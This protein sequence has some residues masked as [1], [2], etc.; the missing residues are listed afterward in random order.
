VRHIYYLPFY[1]QAVKGTTAEESGIRTIPYLVSTALSSI[2]FGAVITITGHYKPLLPIAA[3][4]FAVGAGM[5]STLGV[6][7]NSGMWIGYQVLTGFG[8]GAGVQVPIVAIQAVLNKED[9]AIG[10]AIPMFFNTLGGAISVSISE[11]I[12]ANSL[13]QEVPKFTTGVDPHT[14]ISTGATQIRQVVTADQLQG[15]LH[16]YADALDKVY[17]LP[18]AVAGAAFFV[19]FFVE[20]RNVKGKQM[21]PGAA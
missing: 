13:V 9:M 8:G 17:I 1:F 16:A 7:S 4:I 19:G 11:N 20:G 3:V 12:F 21:A 14:I 5:I 2:I 10:N 15:V 18:Y 6:N